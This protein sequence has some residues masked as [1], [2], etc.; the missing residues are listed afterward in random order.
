MFFAISN[1]PAR[2]RFDIQS[3]S[4]WI[5]P[6]FLGKPHVRFATFTVTIGDDREGLSL[7]TEFRVE[8]SAIAECDAIM[9]V[10]FYRACMRI[11]K[12]LLVRSLYR[13]TD[14]VPTLEVDAL[15]DEECFRYGRS[16]Q[17]D[18]STNNPDSIGDV[19]MSDAHPGGHKVSHVLDTSCGFDNPMSRVS[20]ER[21]AHS[22]SGVSDERAACPVCGVS[23]ECNAHPA[24]GV[25]NERNARPAFGVSNERNARPA[26]GVSNERN[27]RPVFGVSN[28][29]NARLTSEVSAECNVARE[30][31]EDYEMT[32]IPNEEHTGT[33]QNLPSAELL[34]IADNDHNP[35][36]EQEAES[37]LSSGASA[38]NR[39]VVDPYV[40]LSLQEKKRVLNHI[41]FEMNMGAP[42]LRSLCQFHQGISRRHPIQKKDKSGPALKA[43]FSSFAMKTLKA[44]GKLVMTSVDMLLS[45]CAA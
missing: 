29:H 25:S 9:G 27:A 6:A 13:G 39:F 20:D 37:S 15:G 21:N 8:S 40:Y 10:D 44:S 32:D 38:N 5:S 36:S 30:Y 17:E 42:K 18:S 43:L 2:L 33:Y 22:V 4:S 31:A 41:V 14:P 34:C 19:F 24:F 35:L 28:E 7:P 11:G 45:A 23:D 12:E 3:N 26:F 16:A 1:T